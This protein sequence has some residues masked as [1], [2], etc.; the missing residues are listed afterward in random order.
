[1]INL[2]VY[3]KTHSR[4]AAGFFNLVLKQAQRKLLQERIFQKN[5]RHFIELTLVSEKE[6]TKLN[7]KYRNKNCPTDV[8]SLSY[9]DKKSKDSFIGEIF[10]CP[11]FARTQAKKLGNNFKY[12]MRFLFIHG[13]LHV[14]GFDH[15]TK[16]QEEDMDKVTEGILKNKKGTL[17]SSRG[18][19]RSFP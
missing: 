14:F 3:N 13:L 7:K 12:E 9:F 5:R 6:I 8:I 17:R 11:S 16:T 10:I 2:N 4:I 19:H 1:M 18:V 15:K